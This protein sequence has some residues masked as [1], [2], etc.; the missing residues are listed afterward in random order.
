MAESD[1]LSQTYGVHA[2]AGARTGY[3]FAKN[4]QQKRKEEKKRDYSV[5]VE[6]NNVEPGEEKKGVDIKV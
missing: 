1:G 2:V 3:V 4:R 5:E 6:K